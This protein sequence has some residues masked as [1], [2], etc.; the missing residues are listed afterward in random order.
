MSRSSKKLRKG[1]KPQ[2]RKVANKRAKEPQHKKAFEQL[3][4]DAILGLRKK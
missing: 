3:L 1:A 2:K 4:D